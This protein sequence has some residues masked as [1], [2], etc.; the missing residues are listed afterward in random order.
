MH[1]N[2]SPHKKNAQIAKAL[3]HENRLV[4]I[5]ELMR[6]ERCVQELTRAI[7]ADQSTVSKH[8]SVLKNAGIIADRRQGNRVYYR[9]K[10][11]GVFPLF[12]SLKNM[13]GRRNMEKTMSKKSILYLCTG[14]SARS[15]MAEAWTKKLKGGMFEAWSAG[16]DP[17]G[18][19]PRAAQVM[20]EAGLGTEGLVSKGLDDLPEVAFDYV[21]TLCDDAARGCPVF[22]A[23]TRVLHVGF[24]DPPRLAAGAASEEE[25]LAH[26]RRVLFE[27]RD[28]VA[29]LPGVLEV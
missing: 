3:A 15:Q 11:A 8:L 29:G 26:F 13:L 21:V 20:A 16:V 12:W 2:G 4:I 22:P 25:A 10:D 23:R 27:I 5:E 19:N 28:W 6:E 18:L 24:D 14:N 7:G 1:L 9:L 17:Q